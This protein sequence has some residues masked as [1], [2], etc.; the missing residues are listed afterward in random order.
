MSTLGWVHL[1]FGIVA[2]LAGTAVV[3]TRKGT[4]WH[5]TLGHVYLTNMVALNVSALFIYNLFGTFGPFHWLALGSLFSLL[6]GMIP[7]FTRRPKRGWLQ[8]HAA[9]IGGSYVGLLA[10]TAAEITSR[11][12]G[13]E[14]SFGLVVAGTSI[15]V[16]VAG[17]TLVARYLPGSVS[18]VPTRFRRVTEAGR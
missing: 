2:L 15:V 9:F 14:E 8:R 13:T 18:R 11:L 3:L 4:R 12:P 10:A 17:G 7:V 1:T 5:R 16:M 6:V